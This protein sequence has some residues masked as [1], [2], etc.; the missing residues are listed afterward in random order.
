MVVAL[1]DGEYI[2]WADLY[3]NPL[4]ETLISFDDTTDVVTLAANFQRQG[5][6]LN[7]DVLQDEEQAPFVN[8]LGYAEDGNFQGV[9][10]KIVVE[11]GVYKIVDYEDE[12][13]Y[14]AARKSAKSKT[15]RPSFL[16]R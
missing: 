7:A 3:S 16:V 8:T 2:L 1:E 15:P 12:T 4:P 6:T 9:I 5:T 11:N 14:G 13:E 10:A